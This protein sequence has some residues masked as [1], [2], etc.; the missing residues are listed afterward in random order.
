MSVI[1]RKKDYRVEKKFHLRCF[2][3]LVVTTTCPF[4]DAHT[5]H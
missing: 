2:D 3:E 5:I 1:K 4:K